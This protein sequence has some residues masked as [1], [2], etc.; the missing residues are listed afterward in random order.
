MSLFPQQYKLKALRGFFD[1]TT[2]LYI[3]LTESQIKAKN[4]E[5]DASF[6]CLVDNLTGYIE[7]NISDIPDEYVEWDLVGDYVK[8][9]EVRKG[10]QLEWH[11]GPTGDYFMCLVTDEAKTT[12]EYNDWWV[13]KVI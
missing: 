3:P 9:I 13:N 11:Q 12:Q 8:D 4:D 7:V 1:M 10:T 6:E 5:R 2:K